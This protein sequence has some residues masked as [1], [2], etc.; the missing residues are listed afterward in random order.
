MA[1]TNAALRRA[2]RA[3]VLLYHWRCGW[4]LGHRFLLLIHTG[5][6]TGRRR[7]TILEIMEF[8]IAPDEM[9][10]MSGFGRNADWLRNIQANPRIE[11]MVGSRRFAATCRLLDAAEAATVVAGYE[12][13]CRW[14]GRIIRAVLTR[15]LGWRYDGS[16]ASRR[17]LVAQLPLVAF[18]PIADPG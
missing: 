8:R 5:R 7:E 10:V 11:L 1:L 2:F 17:R 14:L 15:L 18:R 16:E 3:P 6:R 13:R 12:R 9:V 4:I